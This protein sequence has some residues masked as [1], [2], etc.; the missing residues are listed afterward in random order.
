MA[1][2]SVPRGCGRNPLGPGRRRA[3]FGCGFASFGEL[4]VD[5]IRL[6]GRA[7]VLDVLSE[8]AAIAVDN[9]QPGDTYRYGPPVSPC[10]PWCGRKHIRYNSSNCSRFIGSVPVPG[11][12]TPARV[13]IWL[14][15]L[16][17][18]AVGEPAIFVDGPRSDDPG[19]L[20]QIDGLRL[21]AQRVIRGR[22]D[23]AGNMVNLVG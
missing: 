4:N 17:G 9:P 1:G 16:N 11:R 22:V 5:F 20:R 3:Q 23:G 8:L 7:G 21:E 6:A 15:R 10:E 18:T 19:V 2:W 12:A 14:P 13:R